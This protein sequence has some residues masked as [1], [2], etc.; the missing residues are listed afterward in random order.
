MEVAHATKK[1]LIISVSEYS[2]TNHLKP[3]SFCKND[4]EEMYELLKSLGY[5]ILEDHKLIG[6]VKNEGCNRRFL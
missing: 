2:S 3:L 4:G 1:A 5:E 6:Y